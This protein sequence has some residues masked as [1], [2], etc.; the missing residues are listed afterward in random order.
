[1]AVASK[2]SVSE[3][4]HTSDFTPERKEEIRKVQN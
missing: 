4:T 1:M 2:R 3:Y